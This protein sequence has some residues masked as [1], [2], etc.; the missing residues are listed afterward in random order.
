MALSTFDI[1]GVGVL[2]FVL[3]LSI[4]TASIGG[5]CYNQ[6]PTFAKTKPGNDTYLGFAVAAPVVGIV[7]LTGFT[8]LLHIAP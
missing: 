3:I 7:A 6:N 5:E 1:F 8:Y 4:A 2:L